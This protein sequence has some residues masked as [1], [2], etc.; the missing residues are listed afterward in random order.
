MNLI[1]YLCNASQTIERMFH[2]YFYIVIY[3]LIIIIDKAIKKCNVFNTRFVWFLC[4]Q[5]VTR[6]VFTVYVV[7]EGGGVYATETRV[8]SIQ[9]LF[10]LTI[11]HTCY[12]ESNR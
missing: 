6:L 11:R 5:S 3:Y 9:R 12:I 1:E 2:L 8:I 10:R 7:Q 4:F